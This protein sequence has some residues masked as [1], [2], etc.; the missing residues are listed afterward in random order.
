M[1]VGGKSVIFNTKSWVKAD[2]SMYR[3][4]DKSLQEVFQ[5]Y[6]NLLNWYN[7]LVQ[8]EVPHSFTPIWSK[9]Q[10]QTSVSCNL[11]GYHDSEFA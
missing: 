8:T 1:K 4:K 10:I 2:A 11:A 7:C 5:Q 6:K 3:K 9:L